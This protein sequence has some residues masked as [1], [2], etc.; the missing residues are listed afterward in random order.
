MFDCP[1]QKNTSP[2]VTRRST[3]VLPGRPDALTL[4]V[5]EPPAGVG[6]SLAFQAVGD[7]P[8]AKPQPR[9]HSGWVLHVVHCVPFAVGSN[10]TTSAAEIKQSQVLHHFGTH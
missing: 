10:D 9:A 8:W 7:G 3:S 1:L 2:K 6:R 4:M 5:Y